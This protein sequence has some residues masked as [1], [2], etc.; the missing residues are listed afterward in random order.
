MWQ[1]YGVPPLAT[2]VPP[3]IM[4]TIR[5]REK[6]DG[7]VSY[8]VQLR[9]KKKGVLVYQESQTFACKHAAQARAKRQTLLKTLDLG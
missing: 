6:A 4:A 3:K 2:L 5:A 9:L 7:T 1:W 8:T